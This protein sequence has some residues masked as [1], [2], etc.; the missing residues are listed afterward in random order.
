ME[1]S[2]GCFI[3]KTKKDDKE[4]NRKRDNDRNTK[5]KRQI[6]EGEEERK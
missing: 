4:T 6:L 2:S 3:K 1:T 5:R